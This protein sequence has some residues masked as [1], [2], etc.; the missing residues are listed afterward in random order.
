MKPLSILFVIFCSLMLSAAISV[1]CL[2]HGV[3]GWA[4]KAEAWCVTAMYD[5]GEP[6]GYAAVE[7][8]SPAS[9]I[10]FQTGRTDGN[11]QFAFL[12]NTEGDWEVVVEDGMGHR[13]ALDIPVSGDVDEEETAAPTVSTTRQNRPMGVVA[14]ISVIFGLCGFFYGW[15]ARRAPA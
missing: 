8:T 10:A 4:E 15:K 11:G 13:L 6:M 14:G 3:E 5:D 12:P 7:V 9:G 2:A 1:T